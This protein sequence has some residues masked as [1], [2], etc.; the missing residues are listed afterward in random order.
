M[1][2]ILVCLSLLAMI[3]SCSTRQQTPARV[4]YDLSSAAA[5]GDIPGLNQKTD[6]DR[7][8]RGV[9]QCAALWRPEDGTQADFEAFVKQWLATS[10]ADREVLFGKLSRAMEIFATQANQLTIELGRPTVLAEGEPGDIDYLFSSHDAY[11]HFSDDMFENKVAFITILNFPHYTL[12]EK[13]SLGGGWDRLQWAYA[14]MGDRFTERVPA[15]VSQAVTVA[16]SAAEGYVDVYNIKMGHLLTE[17][18][19]KI[20]PED[21]SLLSHWNLR[22]ELKSDYADV[23]HAREKQEMIYKVME[24]IVTQEIPAAVVNNPEYDWAP[25]SNRVWKDGKEVSL[26]SEG[27]VR[28][29]HILNQFHTFQEL[30]KWCPAM[31]TAIARN[32]E[33]SIEMTDTEVED[34]FVR[35][36]TS[37]QVKKV[38][39][40]IGQRLGRELRPYDIWYDGFKSRS[41]IPEDKLTAETRKRYPDAEAFHRDMPRQLRNLGF[42]AD[43]AQFLADHIVVEGARGSGH[44]WE[45]VGRT[46][47][48]RLRTRIGEGG[49]DYKGYNIAVHEFGHN[50]E[51]VTDLY[52]IDHYTL[53][54]VPNTATT[55]AMAFLFQVR[56]L[57]LLGYGRQ[58]MDAD[59]TL[60]IFW[61]MYEIM[62]VS[63]VDMYTWRWLYAHPDATASGLRDAVLSIARGVWNKYYEPVLGTH[64]SPLL[65]IYSHMLDYPMYLPNYPIG[66]IIHYQ[67]EEHLAKC[68]SDAAFAA[69]L[70]RIYRQGRLT[71][72]AWMKGAVGSPIS[73]DPIL[74]AV[75]K[76]IYNR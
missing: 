25:F 21:M 63:L 54:G 52:H 47:P 75:E 15:S 35:F 44:A 26:P 24:R 72:Q 61:N 34:L 40:M 30:D 43:E 48:A 33:G 27:D 23:P 55:E 14:R 20:F 38:G 10:P 67:L 13:N 76:I 19:E 70:Q 17:G 1:K 7:M 49:M 3:M 58:T 74:A 31:P 29:G 36:L 59:A 11:A 45:C 9:D 60:D 50:V 28:Y 42:A 4:G 8:Q 22:D 73:I 46:E 62:G 51:Q 56:D 2:R 18:G 16:R 5:S 64:D 6:L 68:G 39:E 57:Q 41:V 71:P 66:H 65:A 32:F 37:D 53:A 12:E 69:E